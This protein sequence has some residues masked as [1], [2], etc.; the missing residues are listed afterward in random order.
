MFTSTEEGHGQCS[1]SRKAAQC[2]DD[3]TDRCLCKVSESF[4]EFPEGDD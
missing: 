3:S 2:F 4:V 1:I